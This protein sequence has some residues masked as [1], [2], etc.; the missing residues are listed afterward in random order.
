MLY[1]ICCTCDVISGIFNRNSLFGIHPRYSRSSPQWRL[2]IVYPKPQISSLKLPTMFVD[3]SSS[4]VVQA[5]PFKRHHCDFEDFSNLLQ[6]NDA[7]TF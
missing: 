5:R 1:V 2:G 4:A 3:L 6:W 7:G